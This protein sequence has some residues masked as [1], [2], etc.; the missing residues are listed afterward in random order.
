MSLPRGILGLTALTFLGFGIASAF[1]PVPMASMV[2]IGLSSS[3]AR[4]DF[5]ATYGGFE[6]GFGAFL[7]LC[8]RRRAWVETGLWAGALALG[9]FATVRLLTLLA[10]EGP[11]RPVI[12]LALALEV[13][14]VV[15]NAWA[16]RE[17][18][19]LP[20]SATS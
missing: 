18:R 6:L 11:V 14:G 15:L 8:L 9:G 10:S 7:L 5:A 17:F 1:W 19:R 2:E 20:G 12:H 4:V 3:T 16:L 13:A